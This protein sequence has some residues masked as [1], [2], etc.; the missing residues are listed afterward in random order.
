[1][2]IWD[3]IIQ[4]LRLARFWGILRVSCRNY[5][6]KSSPKSYFPLRIYLAIPSIYG[7]C[8]DLWY[9]LIKACKRA[10]TDI[11]HFHDSMCKYA[12][13]KAV[14]IIYELLLSVFS[15]LYSWVIDSLKQSLWGISTCEGFVGT[16]YE[17]PLPIDRLR[18]WLLRQRQ[19]FPSFFI[20]NPNHCGLVH[21]IQDVDNGL[22]LFGGNDHEYCANMIDIRLR[23]I[24]QNDLRFKLIEHQDM[25][26]RWQGRVKREAESMDMK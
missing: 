5:H 15:P 11:R 13:A 20:R 26:S 21:F 24:F 7:R 9:H 1:M 6:I 18:V 17:H 16:V 25:R 23:K 14:R 10:E 2:E 12:G 22:H 8:V 19:P 3:T 4:Y